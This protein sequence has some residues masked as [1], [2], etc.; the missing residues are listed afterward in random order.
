M[1]LR[2]EIP[3]D[4]LHHHQHL[5]A[6]MHFWVHLV[7]MPRL[8]DSVWHA[9]YTRLTY[10]EQ[11]GN[12]SDVFSNRSMSLV[13]VSMRNLQHSVPPEHS[14]QVASADWHLL[15]LVCV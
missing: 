11:P 15:Q 14:Y 12:A 6:H 10:S 2:L 13:F 7:E 5:F 1:S 3:F 4:L 8:H 9:W